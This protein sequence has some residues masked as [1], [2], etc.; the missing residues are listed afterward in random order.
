[1]LGSV[2]TMRTR[3]FHTI[4]LGVFLPSACA[5]TA[6]NER[7]EPAPDRDALAAS[8]L[9]GAARVPHQKKFFPNTL[10]SA[11]S[12]VR[13]CKLLRAEEE[14]AENS[15][16]VDQERAFE[17]RARER[18]RALAERYVALV[19]AEGYWFRGYDR[20][21]R[22]LV[23]DPGRALI[24][25]DGG[26]LLPLAQD[27][28]PGFAVGAA[29][30]DR[31]LER[32]AA[33]RLSLR[34]LFRIAGSPLRQDACAWI[35]GGRFV[36]M[37]I[38]VLATALLA[39]DGTVLARGDTG[40]Y[41][42]GSLVTPVRTPTLIPQKGRTAEGRELPAPAQAGLAKLAE[43]ALPCYRAALREQPGLRGT[44]VLGLR[45][46]GAGQVESPVAEMSSLG[47]DPLVRCT[48]AKAAQLRLPEVPAG[49][50]L[51]LPLRFADRD[52]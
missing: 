21:A 2:M 17:T 42:E 30:A 50:R 1:M 22:R 18:Q 20:D 9:T 26:E 41:A 33:G 11:E 37:E 23:L 14:P 27:P 15:S 45:V 38:E 44:L 6:R 32:K 31:L 34:V 16:V 8:P 49:T 13:L 40:E 28:F 10:D 43:K 46:G 36:R 39:E 35:S 19:S 47:N 48:L 4:F 25:G 3:A 12:L 24:L 5:S 52:D 7:A 29:F 51:S